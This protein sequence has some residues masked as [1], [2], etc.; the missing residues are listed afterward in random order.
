LSSA[1]GIA[2]WEIGARGRIAL[3]FAAMPLRHPMVAVVAVAESIAVVFQG[4]PLVPG[5]GR[6]NG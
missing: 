1:L 3:L 4:L 2:Y 5:C 6:G